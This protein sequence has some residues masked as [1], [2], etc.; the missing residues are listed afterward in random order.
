MHALEHL[1]LLLSAR[2]RHETGNKELAD[3]AETFASA[4]H[5][6]VPEGE[7]TLSAVNDAWSRRYG[8]LLTGG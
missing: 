7:E 5:D 8:K 1:L 3:A 4:A 2:I 6:Y